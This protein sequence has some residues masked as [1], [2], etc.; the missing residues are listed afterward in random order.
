M[1]IFTELLNAL[2]GF[3]KR[4][5]KIFC[6]DHMFDDCESQKGMTR[7]MS[8]LNY[9]K[10]REPTSDYL[11]RINKNNE[12]SSKLVTWHENLEELVISFDQTL[13][14]YTPAGNTTLECSGTWNPSYPG[15]WYHFSVL[16]SVAWRVRTSWRSEILLI[17]DIFKAQTEDK[18]LEHLDE[19]NIAHIQVPTNLTF[20][21]QPLELKVNVFRK[22]FLKLWLIEWYTKELKNG[23]NKGKNVHQFDIDT[24]LAKMKL[25]HEKAMDD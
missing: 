17:Y 8:V 23:Q 11:E 1:F 5:S 2:N 6:S 3:R 15:P 7:K 25:I 13:S 10:R 22:K 14:Y 16:R 20:T 18:Y 21:F 12:T 19:K 9:F 4:H 24:K